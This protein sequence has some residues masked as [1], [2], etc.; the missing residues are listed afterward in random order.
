M[1]ILKNYGWKKFAVWSLLLAVL[2]VASCDDASQATVVDKIKVDLALKAAFVKVPEIGAEKSFNE[3]FSA[4]SFHEL[5]VFDQLSL[6]RMARERWESD[7]RF[8]EIDKINI[9]K[10]KAYRL[11]INELSM[12]RFNKPYNQLDEAT[13]EVL[14][15][16]V[17][18][19]GEFESVAY[20][21]KIN[22]G[23]EEVGRTSGSCPSACYPRYLTYEYS[24]YQGVKSNSF[25]F[26]KKLDNCVT[27]QNDCDYQ[28]TY[29]CTSCTRIC[30]THFGITIWLRRNDT[31]ARDTNGHTHILIGAGRVTAMGGAGWVS[32]Y[33]WMRP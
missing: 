23:N 16:D 20:P 19:S 3:K 5:N 18:K 31:T 10:A 29:P 15:D 11:A 24:E 14:M 17:Y 8:M 4:L 6:E 12:K 22:E 13:L 32:Q 1:K 26:M 25:R 27:P 21:E 33:T 28:F 30:A 9:G 7:D 2:S